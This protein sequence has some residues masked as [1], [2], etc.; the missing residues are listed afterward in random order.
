MRKEKLREKMKITSVRAIKPASVIFLL[1]E[2]TIKVFKLWQCF[3][4]PVNVSSTTVIIIISWREQK[5]VRIN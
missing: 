1:L 5:M 2:S 4:M 3:P